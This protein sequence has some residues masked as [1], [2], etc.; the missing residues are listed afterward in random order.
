ML[1]VKQAV[2]GALV[3]LVM[4]AGS[5]LAGQVSG[6]DIE[7]GSGSTAIDITT[8]ETIKPSMFTLSNPARLVVDLPG[9]SLG[10]ST[11][12]AEQFDGT[13][14][15]NMRSGVR[16]GTDLRLVFDLRSTPGTPELSTERAGGHQTTRITMTSSDPIEAIAE[17]QG[18]S[19][20]VAK[21]ARGEGTRDVIIAI[22]PGHGGHDPGAHGADGVQEKTVVLAISRHIVATLNQR[23]GFHA[24]LTR[25]GDT[26][27]P[28]EDRVEIARQHKADFFVSVH[29]N[30]VD[31]TRPRGTMVFALSPHGATSTMASWMAAKEN[32]SSMVGGDGSS[33]SLKGRSK[34][35]RQTLVDLSLESKISDSLV[36]GGDVLEA[37]K[38]VNPVFKSDV[39][40]ANFAVLRSPDIPSLLVETDFLSN[41][42]GERRLASAEFQRKMGRAIGLGLEHHFTSLPPM[43]TLLAWQKNHP[44]EAPPGAGR[45]KVRSGDSLSVIAARLGTSV[46]ALRK[47]NDLSGGAPIH[48]GDV[49][50]VPQA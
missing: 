46:T 8:N 21:R 22:D 29:A 43:G 9:T 4:V 28:L 50:S 41:P 2:I 16:K 44:D 33:L 45:Y 23:R 42:A 12:P 25:T 26:F 7:H 17:R 40:Q 10:G 14:I 5:A 34:V 13:V 37:V 20:T 6:I 15:K 24:F 39:E 35:I 30:T 32:H 1:N 3:S 38:K 19:R 27:I 31:S 18:K 49:L 47:A 48:P 36:A 11:V